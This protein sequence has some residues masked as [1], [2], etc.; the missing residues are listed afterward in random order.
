MYICEIRNTVIVHR[1][2][3]ITLDSYVDIKVG[4]FANW[5][6]RLNRIRKIEGMKNIKQA[7]ESIRRQEKL[8]YEYFMD[9]LGVDPTDQSIYDIT[10][11][12]SLES[13]QM[14]LIKI[15]RYIKSNLESN[16]SR[17]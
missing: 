9:S 17:L 13:L 5:M 15:Q 8:Q 3:L 1:A 10:F 4:I 14:I 7:S 16:F 2:A 11:N 12:S 6:D